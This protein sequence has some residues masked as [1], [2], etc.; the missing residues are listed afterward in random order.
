MKSAV[1]CWDCSVSRT[2][3]CVE[4]DV[5]LGL[6]RSRFTIQLHSIS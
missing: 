2:E 6:N 5:E 3:A 1:L 4:D